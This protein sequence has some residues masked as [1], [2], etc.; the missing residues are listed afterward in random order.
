MFTIVR[1]CLFVIF[2]TA[3]SFA[4]QATE[5]KPVRIGI[6]TAKHEGK[7][8]DLGGTAAKRIVQ[9][10]VADFGGTVAGRPVQ[11][12]EGDHQNRPKVGALIARHWLQHGN[13]DVILDVPNTSVQEAVQPVVR[14]LDGLMIVNGVGYTPPKGCGSHIVVWTYDLT[15]M[16]SFAFA[17]LKEEGFETLTLLNLEP[18]IG[19]EPPLNDIVKNVQFARFNALPVRRK[20]VQRSPGE[21]C[22]AVLFSLRSVVT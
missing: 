3:W 13:V 1:I 2:A 15:S 21:T 20:V 10:A 17:S 4:A 7:G 16:S 11:V 14:E 5:P 19:K 22:C 18:P 6:L 12:I 8:G 9:Q